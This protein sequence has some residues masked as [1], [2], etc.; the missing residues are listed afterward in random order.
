ML[1]AIVTRVTI[2]IIIVWLSGGFESS[3]AASLEPEVHVFGVNSCDFCRDAQRF[4]KQLKVDQ[5]IHLHEHD[6]DGGDAE[7][8]LF[9]NIVESLDLDVPVIPVII[10][11]QHVIIGYDG[12]E[13]TGKEIRE[14][15]KSCRK[16]SCPDLV[17][18]FSG[19]SEGDLPPPLPAW[20]TESRYTRSIVQP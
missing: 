20:N 8:T 19:G 9:L 12:D 3:P 7:E 15:I 10:I 14:A 11:G 13:T 18:L 5:P 16:R 2:A 6:L 4:L 17:P 1:R